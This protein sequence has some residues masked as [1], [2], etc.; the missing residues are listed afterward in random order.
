MNKADMTIRKMKVACK[1]NHCDMSQP[2]M[3]SSLAVSGI[4]VNL[5]LNPL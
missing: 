5:T 2:I 3:M 1:H 4:G